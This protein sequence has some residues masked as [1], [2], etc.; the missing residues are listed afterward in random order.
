MGRKLSE[1]TSPLRT[2]ARSRCRCGKR[3]AESRC[4]RGG[5]A[6]SPGADVAAA[7]RVP[8]QMW[9]RRAQPLATSCLASQSSARLATAHTAAWSHRKRYSG[10][11]SA[12]GLAGSSGRASG[13]VRRFKPESWAARAINGARQPPVVYIHIAR[14]RCSRGRSL[15]PACLRDYKGRATWH[16]SS[17]RSCGRTGGRSLHA[18]TDCGVRVPAGTRSIVLAAV[19]VRT[20]S[21]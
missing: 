19:G 5:G 6:P 13:L 11:A 2:Q 12:P 1:D 3:W 17:A 4:R 10:P 7:S 15:A 14:Q 21:R 9:Q 20:T 8:E 18:G 16:R